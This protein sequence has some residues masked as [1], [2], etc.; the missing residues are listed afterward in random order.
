MRAKTGREYNRSKVY[1][2]PKT[3]N[4]EKIISTWN[5]RVATA[6]AIE[7]LERIEEKRRELLEQDANS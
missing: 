3:T 5:E 4:P 7:A 6:R 1:A 2:P